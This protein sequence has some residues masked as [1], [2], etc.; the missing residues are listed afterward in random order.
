M[1]TKGLMTAGVLLG[2]G[3]LTILKLPIR[4]SKP[5]MRMPGWLQ[6]LILHF[7]YGSWIGGVTGHLVAGFMSIPWFFI[8]ELYL[9]PTILEC[10]RPK[11]AD[12]FH[13]KTS[14]PQVI[15]GK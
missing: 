11:L 10:T 15:T 6:S 7:G 12:L 2:I 5:L 8:S 13:R 1:L 3:T 9:R 14:Q 4:I